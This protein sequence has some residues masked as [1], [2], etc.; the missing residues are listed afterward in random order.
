LALTHPGGNWPHT[1]AIDQPTRVLLALSQAGDE[2]EA[3]AAEAAALSPTQ[4]Q[5]LLTLL[6]RQRLGPWVGHQ[7]E[8]TGWLV[9]LPEVLQSPLRQ[10]TARAKQRSARQRLALL[11]T[12]RCLQAHGIAAV[13]LKGA[14]LAWQHYPQPWL[15]P[16]RDLDLLLPEEQIGPAFALL[17]RQ[18]FRVQG[19]S[20]RRPDDPLMWRVNDFSLWHPSGEL[21][22][23]HRSLWFRPGDILHGDFSLEPAFWAQEPP[24]RLPPDPQGLSHLQPTYLT[25]HCLVHHLIR[26][27]MDMGPLGLVDLQLLQAAGHL[28]S[29]ELAAAAERLGFASLLATAHTVLADWRHT[30][31][32]TAPSVPSWV[33]PL[34]MSREQNL[35]IY[36]DDRSMRSHARQWLAIQARGGRWSGPAP[37]RTGQLFHL[38]RAITLLPA[39]VGKAG[40]VRQI[41]R[42]LGQH[43]VAPAE[44][45]LPPEL[46]AATRQLQARTRDLPEASPP[47]PW[48]SHNA[49]TVIER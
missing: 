17:E 46:V 48:P 49:H 4:A 10:A 13:A 36:L 15:R 26:Q 29:P 2:L 19:A 47:A 12:V 11:H 43:P 25:L 6:G 37:S 9:T 33:L 44:G 1:T 28:D 34:M 14:H 8:Q 41:Q 21:I 3:A 32:L 45:Q 38:A 24:Y 20:V 18:G 5:Q 31:W 7:L 42:R 35:V 39:M 30:R 23:L 22:E 40:V 16:M 27:N